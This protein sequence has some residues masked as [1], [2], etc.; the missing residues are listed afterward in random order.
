[1]VREAHTAGLVVH[2]YT[3]RADKGQLPSYAED[4]EALL[5]IFFVQVGVDGVFT[6]F[7]DRAVQY[8]R[9]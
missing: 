1:M 3:L 6:D 8:L 7:P 9:R 4:F 2:P 5:D